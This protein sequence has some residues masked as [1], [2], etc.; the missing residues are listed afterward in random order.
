MSLTRRDLVVQGALATGAL[1]TASRLFAQPPAP[2]PAA[3]PPELVPVWEELRGGVGTFTASGGTIGWLVTPDATVVVD[4]QMPDPARL[5]LAGLR[6][7]TARKIDLVVNTHHHWDHTG[8]N[9]VL[10]PEAI[11][12]VAHANVPA[13]Q[14]R[15]AE[16]GDLPPQTYA[17]TTFTD[18]WRRDLGA[19]AVSARYFGPAHTG[20]DIVVHFEKADVVHMGD[21]VFNRLY[22][23]IDRPAGA[24]IRGWIEVLEKAAAHH[25]TSPR[26]LFGHAR[27]GQPV[28]GTHADLLYQRD[29]F[30][31]LL[32]YARKGLAA[33]RSVEEIAAAETLPGFP[34]HAGRG[35]M[36]SLAAN[37]RLACEELAGG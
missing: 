25:G 30:T 4:T 21:L 28:A 13:L 29:Y 35:T 27:P 15:A 10:R 16:K 33:G 3:T 17:D 8:G 19:E 22:P 5:F 11:S 14:R 23:V 6:E 12:I 36:L 18:A 24:S 32:D 2:A 37:L 1:L 7:R 26:Y 31:A 34:D 9:G 20:G